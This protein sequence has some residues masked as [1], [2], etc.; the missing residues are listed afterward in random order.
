[1]SADN[2]INPSVPSPDNPPESGLSI[3]IE[4]SSDLDAELDA[5]LDTDLNADL[6]AD[7]SGSLDIDLHADLRRAAKASPPPL[8]FLSVNYYSAALLSDLMHTL[9]TNHGIVIVNNSPSDRM[10]HGLAGQVYAGGEVT[11]LDAPDNGGFG[12][13]CNLGL[14]WIYARSPNALVW[15]INPDTCLMPHAV[16]TVR[17]CFQQQ[18]QHREIAILGTPILDLNG[19]AWFSEGRFNRWTGSVQ[20][21]LPLKRPIDTRGRPV[22]TRW[23]SGCSMVLNLGELGHCPQFDDVYFLYYEDCDL[24][25]R[26]FQQDYMLAIAPVPLVVHAVSSITGRHPSP[27]Y[28]HATFSKLT[29][30]RRHAT[31]LALALNII[32]LFAQSVLL[33]FTNPIAAKGR[34]IGL[35]HFFRGERTYPSIGVSR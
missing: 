14:A 17:Q 29:F 15:L 1:M 22:P 18:V 31:P 8:Y 2:P 25:E 33:R 6:N 20:S 9:D 3:D 16:S 12:S 7:L 10:V 19:K 26:Y 35:Q 4:Y 23:V 24:C 30:L 21:S 32:Y 34:W 13:G 11:V 28:I 5:D 27:K